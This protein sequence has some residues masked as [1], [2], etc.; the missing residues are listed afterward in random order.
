MCIRDSLKAGVTDGG[1]A[2]IGFRHSLALSAADHVVGQSVAEDNDYLV[3]LTPLFKVE[4]RRGQREPVAVIGC[5]A[6]LDVYKRQLQ[7]SILRISCP[8]HFARLYSI[9]FFSF[10]NRQNQQGNERITALL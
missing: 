3:L 10:C 2:D 9:P 8:F 5:G 6:V 1:V 7:F 4:S